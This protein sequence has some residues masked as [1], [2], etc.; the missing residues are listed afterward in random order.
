M[1]RLPVGAVVRATDTGSVSESNID[2]EVRVREGRDSKG[3][4][5]S[6]GSPTTTGL[7]YSMV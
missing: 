4:S 6:L 3:E 1:P 2:S 7:S 5:P